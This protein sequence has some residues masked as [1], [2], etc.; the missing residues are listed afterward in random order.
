MEWSNVRV[1]TELMDAADVP[2]TRTTD[3]L[4]STNGSAPSPRAKLFDSDVYVHTIAA[5]RHNV[6]HQR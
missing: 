2:D 6:M 5:S 3:A 4:Y 1:Q